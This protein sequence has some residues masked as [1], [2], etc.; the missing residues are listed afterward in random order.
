M[1][2]TRIGQTCLGG[3]FTGYNRIKSKVYAIIVSPKSTERELQWKTNMYGLLLPES[4]CNGHKNTQLIK[5]T[6]FPAAMYC[7]KLKVGKYRGWYLPSKNEIELCYRYLKPTTDENLPS[8]DEHS[9][10]NFLKTPEGCNPS[11]IPLKQ[12][13]TW[14]DPQQT[15]VLR[16]QQNSNESFDGWYWSST[17]VDESTWKVLMQFFSTGHQYFNIPTFEYAVRAVRRVKVASITT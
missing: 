1:I 10:K 4:K 14:E 7:S 11:S 17:A 3:T 9:F 13:Y 12:S 16:F 6:G 8:D 5:R 2:P 15:V